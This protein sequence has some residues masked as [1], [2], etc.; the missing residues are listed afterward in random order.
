MIFV[1]IFLLLNDL[2]R[3]R[4]PAPE[5]NIE[6]DGYR[7]TKLCDGHLYHQGASVCA[8]TQVAAYTHGFHCTLV[9]LK[10]VLAGTYGERSL[11]A[12]SISGV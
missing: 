5:L 1:E 4:H 11:L 3:G 12:R 6:V 10:L 8:S 7:F 9:G 2:F